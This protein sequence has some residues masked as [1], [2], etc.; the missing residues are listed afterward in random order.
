MLNNTPANTR[1]SSKI[2]LAWIPHAITVS[3]LVLAQFSIYYIL[4]SQWRTA[5]F[6]MALSVVTDSID[7]TL[8]RRLNTTK[9]IPHIDGH[10]LDSITDYVI[11]VIVPTIYIYNSQIIPTS[12]LSIILPL[13]L[14]SSLYQFSHINSKT[15]DN[16]FRGFPS[17]WNI[18]VLYMEVLNFKSETNLIILIVL[19]ILIYVPTKYYYPSRTKR[20]ARLVLSISIFWGLSG[21]TLIY[22]YPKPQPYALFTMMLCSLV[23]ITLTIKDAFSKTNK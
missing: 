10:L 5:L 16:Y 11:Y 4:Q 7:G 17:Y 23:Y 8:A 18:Y 2:I 22:L 9:L 12:Y 14:V 20:H 15:T 13:I 3:G 1:R 19:L 6:L 21:F